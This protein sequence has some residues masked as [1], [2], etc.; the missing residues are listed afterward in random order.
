MIKGLIHRQ[1]Y[2]VLLEPYANSFNKGSEVGTP[3]DEPLNKPGVW[4]R[5][6]EIDSLC[7]VIRLSYQYWKATNDISAFDDEWK[8][9]MRL[10]VKTFKAEQL[11]KEKVRMFSFA[12]PIG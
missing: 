10:I 4:E 7:Y 5:K 1:A 3:T 8:S 2:S 11:K 12:K 9:A 6:W